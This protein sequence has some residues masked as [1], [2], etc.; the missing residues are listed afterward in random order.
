MDL[1]QDCKKDPLADKQTLP[2]QVSDVFARMVEEF[3]QQ[4]RQALEELA[5]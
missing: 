1:S 2:A 3:I 5:K 4:Y